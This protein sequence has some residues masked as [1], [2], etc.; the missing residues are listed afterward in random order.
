MKKI[1]LIA[2]LLMVVLALGLGSCKKDKMVLI[3]IENGTGHDMT[4]ITVGGP[5]DIH[6]YE[7]LK[8]GDKSDYKVYQKAYRY[9]YL[10]FKIGESDFVVQPIDY[11]GE[12]LLEPGKYTYLV[13]ISDLDTP[14]A[15]IDLK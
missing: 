5:E 11:V 1:S 9:A 7:D 8:E 3:R 15:N 14:W 12:S 13:T 4:A 6:E 10:S 2:A